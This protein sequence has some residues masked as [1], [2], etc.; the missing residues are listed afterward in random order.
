VNKHE[1]HSNETCS[2]KP[3]RTRPNPRLA[4][5]LLGHFTHMSILARFVLIPSLLLFVGCSTTDKRANSKPTIAVTI[6]FG[7]RDSLLPYRPSSRHSNS[8]YVLLTNVSGKPVRV[9]QEW[10]S[11]GYY[12]LQCEVFREDG[13][14]HLLKKKPTNFYMN[15]PDFVELQPGESVVWNVELYPLGWEGLSWLPKDRV[16]HVKLRAIYTTSVDQDSKEYG[17]WTGQAASEMYDFIL[18]AP[19]TS[20]TR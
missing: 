5:F 3:C 2:A 13:T 7:S 10:C 20:E 4:E 12:S 19:T 8:F 9:W 1:Y 16:E 14:K 6:P 17:V 18:S 15:F 11:W